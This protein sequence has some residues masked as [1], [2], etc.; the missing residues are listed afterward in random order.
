MCAGDCS[1]LLFVSGR[2]EMYVPSIK[3]AI[4]EI[5]KY[6]AD[7]TKRFH[8]E[9]NILVLITFFSLQRT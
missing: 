4:S 7:Y 5:I 3:W 8:Y 9:K 2:K 1:L 6:T